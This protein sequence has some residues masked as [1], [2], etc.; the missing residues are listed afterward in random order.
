MRQRNAIA[1]LVLLAV[2]VPA[3]AAQRVRIS[4]MGLFHP[5]QLVVAAAPGET[6]VVT[7]GKKE[8]TV[9]DGRPVTLRRSEQQIVVTGE[10]RRLRAAR[11]KFTSQQGTDAEFV[12]SL[13]GKLHRRYRG[14]LSVLAAQANL[15]VV[16]DMD[17]ETAVASI[18]AA[19]LP[20]DIAPL[21]ALKAQAVAVRAYLVAGEKRHAYADFCDTTHCQFLRNPPPAGSPPAR[22][23]LAT[24][25]LVLAWKGQPFAAMYSAACGGR[26]R[27]AT[28][29]ETAGG[30]YPY[31]AVDC[32]YCRRRALKRR[33]HGVGMCQTGASGM[34]R[35]GKPFRAILAHYFP[36]TTIE[37]L[38]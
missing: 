18:V 28:K 26:T 7:A 13:P 14:E 15:V 2:A 24:E 16:V 20:S 34:A 32:A 12:L 17:L 9:A 10:R 31:F 35:D 30:D 22:A 4:V 37:S 5:Q 1:V 21:E 19:E 6:L 25:G 27:S 11:V 36:N 29:A 23:T 38:R 3:S 33:G 8:F